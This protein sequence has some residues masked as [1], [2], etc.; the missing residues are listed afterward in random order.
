MISKHS[1]SVAKMHAGPSETTI[2]YFIRDQIYN[3]SVPALSTM[4]LSTPPYTLLVLLE[5]SHQAK[6]HQ[7]TAMSYVLIIDL[8]FAY[9]MCIY[10][11]DCTCILCICMSVA[12]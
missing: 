5:D 7:A 4:C 11:Y 2:Q 3:A 6:Q 1:F 9:N 10:I 8:L 12:N